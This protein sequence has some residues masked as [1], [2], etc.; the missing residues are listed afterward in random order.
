M[1]TGFGSKKFTSYPDDQTV[2]IN[3]GNSELNPIVIRYAEV[4]LTYA[5][6][7]NESGSVPNE[8]VYSALNKIRKRPTVN[9]PEIQPGLS[10]EQMREVIRLERRIELALEGFYNSDIRRWRIAEIVNNKPVLNHENK[11]Y[12]NRTFNK[13]RDYLWPIPADEIVENSNLV[14]N[15]GW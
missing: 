5:E 2:K 8:E 4:L 14:Q 6:A 11:L 10:K 12:E 1:T 3:I 15:P 7:L 13:N 9:M